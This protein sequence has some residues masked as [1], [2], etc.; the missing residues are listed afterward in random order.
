MIIQNY[1]QYRAACKAWI[2]L[3]AARY[4]IV[5]YPVPQASEYEQ[6]LDKALITYEM[7]TTDPEFHGK[8]VEL[9]RNRLNTP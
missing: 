3:N 5:V 6:E 8:V 1:K 7:T 9:S 2:P 4:S